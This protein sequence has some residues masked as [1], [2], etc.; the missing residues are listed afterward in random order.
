MTASSTRSSGSGSSSQ[1]GA[2]LAVVCALAFALLS[3]SISQGG[4]GRVSVCPAG[5]G[6]TAGCLS[7][8]GANDSIAAT[9]ATTHWSANDSVGAKMSTLFAHQVDGD[10]ININININ[11]AQIEINAEADAA[12]RELEIRNA[13]VASFVPPTECQAAGFLDPRGVQWLCRY[14]FPML[15]EA[16][17]LCPDGTKRDSMSCIPS[18]FHW[19]AGGVLLK[20]SSIAAPAADTLLAAPPTFCPSDGWTDPITGTVFKC[21]TKASPPMLDLTR[22]GAFKASAG[23]FLATL[24]CPA[25]TTLEHGKCLSPGWSHETKNCWRDL[26][27][28][29]ER[30]P[31]HKLVFHNVKL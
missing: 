31:C 19:M 2:L 29:P 3:M 26:D 8:L 27:C 16:R 20:T 21:D 24:A 4:P 14:D 17:L 9:T 7:L 15:Y 10:N 11:E 18:G 6:A 5:A 30:Y 22:G 23:L 25:S 28:T 1:G 12:A 13:L